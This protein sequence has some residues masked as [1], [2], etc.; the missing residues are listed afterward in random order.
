MGEDARATA[1]EEIV[2]IA[3]RL[4]LLGYLPGTSGNISVRISKGEILTT[5]SGIKKGEMAVEQ[6][7]TVDLDGN[8]KEE[9]RSPGTRR[10]G[11]PAAPSSELPMHLVIYRE[12][13]DVRVVVH[14]HP[15]YCTA[16][17][18]AGISLDR[19]L[20]PEVVVS[21]GEIPVVEYGTPSTQELP[22]AV[23]S[24]LRNHN[25]FLLANH[26]A[27]VIGQEPI[28]ALHKMETMEF[29]AQ[30]AFLARCLGSQ[31]EL[32]EKELIRLMEAREKS[33][34]GY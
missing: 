24:H 20:M 16:F 4:D 25:V 8:V 1:K 3:R 21:L 29:F 31:K 34:A 30:V 9:G 22:E 10:V 19:P 14:A 28:Q 7:L 27:L 13:P 33:Q 18:V 6:I 12:R 2:R 5:P 17:A 23:R 15:P 11:K 32:G 26:G